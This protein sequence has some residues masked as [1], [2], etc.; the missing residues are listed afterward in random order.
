MGAKLRIHEI[1]SV[2]RAGDRVSRVF[3]VGIVVLIVLNV[4]AVVVESVA[5]AARAY[6]GWLWWFEVFS[7]G[8]FSVEY[9]L[10][11]WACT[12]EA[13]YRGS[14]RGRLRYMVTPMALVDLW[15]VLPFYLPFLGVDLRFLRALRLFR[16]LRVAKLGRYS[17]ALQRLV[18]AFRRKKEELTNTVFILAMLLVV[19][20]SV[21]YYAEHAAQPE[22]FS[23]IPAAM[24]WGIC[25]L[26]TVGYGDMYP[27]TVVGKV[28]GSVIA[29]LGIGMF[30]L[31]TAIIGAGFLEVRERE[32]GAGICP[33]CGRDLSKEKAKR[34]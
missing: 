30:A 31:P 16:I 27:V 7:V 10:R 29:V 2:A 23:S 8:I 5:S 33:H 9:G 14:I 11:V 4:A 22:V 1:L 3:D 18:E 28:V 12:E 26:S 34:E 15:A 19:A 32:R 21:M 24:W 6:G 17:A 25:T 20:S 13:G